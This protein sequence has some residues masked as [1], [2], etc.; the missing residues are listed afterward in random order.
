QEQ[1]DA[2]C[3]L[4]QTH[5]R[6]AALPRFCI[7]QLGLAR[8]EPGLGFGEPRSRL[9]IGRRGT[10]VF[11]FAPS[12]LETP[13]RGSQIGICGSRFSLVRQFRDANAPALGFFFGG[14]LRLRALRRLV[15][16]SAACRFGAHTI[17]F[18]RFFSR[19]GLRLC[20]SNVEDRGQLFG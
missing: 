16:R 13:P 7:L 2:C 20:C 12:H 11:P 4:L 10:D 8:R 18:G 5:E 15:L 17:F 14:S 9:W 6:L 19:G 1:L 3:E